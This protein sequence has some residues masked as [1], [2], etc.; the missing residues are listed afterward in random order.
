MALTKRSS[1][2]ISNH[3][4]VIL[5]SKL[6]SSN[7]PVSDHELGVRVGPMF[8]GLHGDLIVRMLVSPLGG[9]Q[10]DS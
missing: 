8:N 3:S 10:F 4:K 5:L 7:D 2:L 9:L 6:S 1:L